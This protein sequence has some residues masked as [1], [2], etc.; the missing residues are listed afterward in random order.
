[1]IVTCKIETQDMENDNGCEVEGTVAACS[2]CGHRTESFG[3]SNGSIKRCF[4]LMR[5]ECPRREQNYY[6]AE[7]A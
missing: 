1:M 2:K 4:W 6:R 3:T 7:E 5:Q